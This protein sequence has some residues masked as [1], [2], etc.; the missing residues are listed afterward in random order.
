M[1]SPIRRRSPKRNTAIKNATTRIPIRIPSKYL[2]VAACPLPFTHSVFT[3]SG[4][5]KFRDCLDIFTI[6]RLGYILAPD[7]LRKN[8]QYTVATDHNYGAQ[9]PPSLGPE[10]KNS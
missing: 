8:P 2:M 9:P 4:W 7:T 6:G 1:T 3:N 5:H 10:R